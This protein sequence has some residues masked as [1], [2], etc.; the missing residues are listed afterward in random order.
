MSPTLAHFIIQHTY[1][2]LFEENISQLVERKTTCV[3]NR[4]RLERKKRAANIYTNP[5]PYSQRPNPHSKTHKI[6]KSKMEEEY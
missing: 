3:I 4:K 2:A 6:K 1:L 5:T